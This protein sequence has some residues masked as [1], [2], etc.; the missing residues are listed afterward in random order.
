MRQRSLRRQ[1]L[2]D[3]EADRG[4]GEGGVKLSDRRGREQRSERDGRTL[5]RLTM[6]MTLLWRWP[7]LR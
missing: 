3:A 7:P 5:R 4:E 1:E 6:A 2:R